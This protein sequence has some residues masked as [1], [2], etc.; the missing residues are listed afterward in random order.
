MARNPLDMGRYSFVAVGDPRAM[1]LTFGSACHGAG[2]V[3][4]RTQANKLLKGRDIRKE[5][6]DAGTFAMANSWA[7]LAEEASATYKGVPG[8]VRVSEGAGLCRA[9][10]RLRPLG[11]IKG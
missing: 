11:V 1:S 9:V 6:G 4:S 5:P 2:R 3:E 10:A 7:S 8:V